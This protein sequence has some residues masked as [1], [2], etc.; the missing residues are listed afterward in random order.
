MRVGSNNSISPPNGHTLKNIL[1]I[2]WKSIGDVVFTLPA[3]RCLRSNFPNSRI[4]YLTSPEFAPLIESFSLVDEVLVLDR[5]RL[6]RF[7]HGWLRELVKLWRILARGHYDIVV[8]LQSY[9]E[10]AWLAWLTRAPQ[11]W[12]LIHR[13][14]RAWAYTRAVTRDEK[15]H[16]ADANLQCL[17]A[18]GLDTSDPGN[19]F[20]LPPENQKAS[21]RLTL[22]FG[23]KPDQPT[24]FIQPFT[25]TPNKNWPLGKWL[26]LG[27]QLRESEIQVLFG[28]GPADRVRLIPAASEN[29]PIAAG[30]DLLTSCALAARCELIIGSDTGL[31][32]LAN[33]AGCRVVLLT[34]LHAKGFPYGHPD[35]VL[36]P[37]RAGSPVAEIE[38]ETV[39]DEIHRVI[40]RRSMVSS[41]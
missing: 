14:S 18:C 34:H 32:H 27:R 26:A 6:K 30:A 15:A 11:R 4:S 12:G 9:G 19:C 17:A 37:Q 25:S 3:L 36:T 22:E 38:V 5:V 7:Q 16:P 33:A 29:F 35:W 24:V 2:R 31:L 13:P 1:L 10:T 39:L 23:L 40:G 8:D 28:G 41:P 21:E 20:K